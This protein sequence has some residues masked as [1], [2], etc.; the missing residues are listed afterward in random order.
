MSEILEVV[1]DT[2]TQV[3]ATEEVEPVIPTLTALDR[4]DRCSAAALH[5]CTSPT[6]PADLMFCGHH[7]RKYAPKMQATGWTIHEDSEALSL[8]QAR[9]G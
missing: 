2:T 5:V 4:C 7:A 6:A 8:A 9:R 3:T 1:P